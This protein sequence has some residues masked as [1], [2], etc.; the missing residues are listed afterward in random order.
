L[1]R[2]RLLLLL[3]CCLVALATPAAASAAL[4]HATRTIA[5]G[6]LTRYADPDGRVVRRDQGG[7]TVS[8]GQAQG[9]LVA[10]AL[11]QRSEFA[12][13]WGWTRRHL[14]LAPGLLAS[15][16]KS[17]RVTNPEPASDADLD[18]ARFPTYYG[19]AW[20]AVASIE[21]SGSALGGY[22]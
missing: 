21:L 11:G 13:V 12:R 6:F 16:W 7:D 3:S 5:T 14:E 10:A 19:S 8:A 15:D 17:G 4:S 1:R 2:P 20:I 22:G 9:M 18:A